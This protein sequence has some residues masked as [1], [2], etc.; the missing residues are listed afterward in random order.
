MAKAIAKMGWWIKK[1]TYN[2]ADD[3]ATTFGAITAFPARVVD[4]LLSSEDHLVFYPKLNYVA[5]DTF[6]ASLFRQIGRGIGALIGGIIGFA[7]GLLTCLIAPIVQKSPEE[8][9]MSQ[10][11]SSLGALPGIGSHIS[12]QLNLNLGQGVSPMAGFSQLLS[13]LNGN[14][15]QS[16]NGFGRNAGPVAPGGA[17]SAFAASSPVMFA[18]PQVGGDNNPQLNQIMEQLINAGNARSFNYNSGSR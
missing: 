12:S 7:L 3:F 15:A 2:W 17:N 18:F 11:N 13:E 8:E 14:L 10:L 6:F 9:M 4:R 5:Q 1:H 16:G